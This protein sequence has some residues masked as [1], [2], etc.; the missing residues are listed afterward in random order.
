[1]TTP[2]DDRFLGREL[3]KAAVQR[4]IFCP[5]S[6]VILDMRRAV[7]LDSTDAPQGGTMTIMTGD[8][9]D[10]LLGILADQGS[11]LEA[12]YGRPVVVY[13]GRVL[14]GKK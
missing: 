1:M 3:V 4:Q 8:V 13:D 12:A 6:N 9:Y 7:L 10:K 11:S 14:F 2:L 5:F